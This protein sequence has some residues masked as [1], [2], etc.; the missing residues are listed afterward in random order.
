MP[1]YKKQKEWVIEEIH[2]EREFYEDDEYAEYFIEN[3]FF[4]LYDYVRGED[5]YTWADENRKF[6][7]A[8]YQEAIEEDDPDIFKEDV[9]LDP[10]LSWASNAYGQVKRRIQ[11]IPSSILFEKVKKVVDSIEKGNTNLDELFD[12]GRIPKK[13]GKAIVTE[14]M[15]RLY[16]EKCPIINRRSEFFYSNLPMAKDYTKVS[17]NEYAEVFTEMGNIVIT[18]AELPEKYKKYPLAL[19][20]RIAFM[21]SVDANHWEAY[22]EFHNRE[23]DWT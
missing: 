3:E 18:E 23:D 22:S 5:I 15:Y 17:L 14:W 19:A 20:D 9:L 6:V 8:K 2:K 16:P 10:Y 7:H 13:T 12:M 11:G 4:T 21:Y 1:L